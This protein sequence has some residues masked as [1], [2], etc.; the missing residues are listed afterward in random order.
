MHMSAHTHTHTHTHTSLKQSW[1]LHPVCKWLVDLCAALPCSGK[2]EM[3]P[4][5]WGSNLGLPGS[6]GIILKPILLPK[7]VAW[8]GKRNP[9]VRGCRVW[10][11]QD[12]PPKKSL[13]TVME[14]LQGPGKG[15]SRNSHMCWP[16]HEAAVNIC[17]MQTACGPW[18][19]QWRQQL[20]GGEGGGKKG[21]SP[22]PSV[23]CAGI[24][25][26]GKRRLDASQPLVTATQDLVNE[27][28]K[29]GSWVCSS[30]LPGQRGGLSPLT[31]I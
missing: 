21:S 22:L 28:R 14:C 12:W 7:S 25:P 18:D 3:V 24:R 27:S 11:C 1:Y 17:Q 20:V 5:S 16:K 8:R 2:K 26:A 4:E 19:R 6:V 15:V 29:Q 13:P 30:W 10:G 23:V 9:P 31:K